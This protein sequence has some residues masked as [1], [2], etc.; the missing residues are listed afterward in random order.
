MDIRQAAQNALVALRLAV[1][2]VMSTITW[3]HRLSQVMTEAELADVAA[4]AEFSAWYERRPISK[5]NEAAARRSGI[6]LLERRLKTIRTAES[7][8]HNAAKTTPVHRRPYRHLPLQYP[9][10]SLSC[11]RGSTRCSVGAWRRTCASSNPW[12]VLRLYVTALV[13]FYFAPPKKRPAA[14]EKVVVLSSHFVTLVWRRYRSG[15]CL[16]SGCVK[17]SRISLHPKCGALCS[18]RVECNKHGRYLGMRSHEMSM[19]FCSLSFSV[20]GHWH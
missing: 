2:C 15:I 1:R 16:I 4:N 12:L 13:P 8:R 18:M 7:V 19:W 5:A 9:Y 6:E 17:P 3:Q 10:P 11:C 14:L 20:A